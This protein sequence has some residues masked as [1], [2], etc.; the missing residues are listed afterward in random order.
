MLMADDGGGP[1]GP[2]AP[3]RAASSGTRCWVMSEGAAGMEVQARGLAEALGLEPTIKRIV[4]RSPWRQLTPF[5]RFGLGLAVGSGS[6]PLRPPWPELVIT[7]G[8][9]SIAPGLWLRRRH[10]AFLV[11]IQDPRIDPRHFDVVVAPRHDRLSG[12]NV[13]VT[14]GSLHRVTKARLRAETERFAGML[15]GVPAPRLAVL[16]GGSNAAYRLTERR[17]TA[18][19]GSLA[20]LSR[21]GHG[22][23]ITPSRRTDP[24]SMAALRAGLAGVPALFWDGAGANPYLAFLGAADAFLVTKDS[25]NLTCEAAATGK[26]VH[27]VELDGGSARFERFHAGLRADGVTR[28]FCGRIESWSYPPLDDTARVAAEIRARLAHAGLMEH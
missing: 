18:L 21:Q 24:K 20:A 3:V 11:H 10:G 14:R 25:V 19:A 2:G 22:L 1:D 7:T 26:P 27:I 13:L 23:M 9:R 15:A 4:L 5:L 6:S 17:M 16:I 12:P 28:P 8:R